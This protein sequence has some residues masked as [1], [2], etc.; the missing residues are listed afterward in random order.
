MAGIA[1]DTWR[2]FEVHVGEPT[3]HLPPDN[4]QTVPSTMVA[5]RTS[6]TNMGLYLLAVACARSFGWIDTAQLLSRCEATLDTLDTL[7]RHRGHF[8]NWYD[9]RTLQILKPAYVSTV[10]S[11]ILCGHLLALAGACDVW[12]KSMFDG[13]VLGAIWRVMRYADRQSQSGCE[14][15][16]S[17]L[18][19]VMV[20]GIAAS[21]VA[22]Y[23]QFFG[24][25]ILMSAML[26]PPVGNAI[27]EEVARIV[28]HV[29]V[30]VPFVYG[31]VIDA[32]RNHLAL[33]GTGEVVVKRLDADLSVGVS[34]SGEIPHQ[35]FF[36]GVY[37]DCGVFGLQ[38]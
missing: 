30:N 32:V 10:D 31:Q 7:E 38:V 18:E 33:P 27:T 13:I 20:T 19:D 28:A 4:V 1:R 14:A 11:G 25:R 5:E 21:A 15:L 8:L 29:Q 12:K 16:Q 34:F 6:P 35:L 36:L 17:F 9:T 3:H 24:F 23:Q 22:K 26:I 37:T 2:F